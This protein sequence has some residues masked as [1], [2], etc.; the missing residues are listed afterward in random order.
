MKRGPIIILVV[1]ITISC[2]LLF[3][4]SR[5]I[6]TG[7]AYVPDSAV[8]ERLAAEKQRLEGGRTWLGAAWKERR[9][10][11][12]IISMTGGP[13]EMGYQHGTLLRDEIFSGV[14]PVFADPVTN[15]REHRAKPMFLRKLMLAYLD[16]A[17]FGPLERNTPSE[18][19]M[20]LKGIADGSG[21]G[22]RDLVR[23]TFKSELTMIM[24]P[25]VVKGK[26][27]SLGISAECSDFAAAGSATADGKLI[28]GRNT[29][30]AG[31]GR[32][33]DAQTVF[34]YRPLQGYAYVN[35]ST[36]GLIKCNSAV[37]E[38]GIVIGGH[39]MGFD[40]TGPRGMSF[41][42]LE[43]EIMRKA[44]T[45]DEAVDIVKRGPRAG[46]FGFMVADGAKRDAVA[47]EANGELVGVRRMENGV[48]VLTNFATTVELEKVDLMKRNNL[49]MRDM[50]GRY[51]R[52]GELIAASR[53]RITG[54]MAAS[55]M[56]DRLDMVTRT[57]RATGITV[58]AANNVTSAVFIPEDGIVWIASGVEPACDGRFHGLDVRAELTG[59]PPRRLPV[60]TGY[61]WKENSKQKGLRH[62]MKAYAAHEED[63]FDTTKIMTNLNAAIAL[64]PNESIYLRL[65][66]SL[67]L[68][69][70]TYKEAITLLERSLDMPQSNSERAHALLL[71]GQGLDLMGERDRAIA[72]YRMAEAI[73]AAHG[74]DILKGVN[75]MLAGFCKKYIEKPFT[76]KQIADIPVAFSSESGIE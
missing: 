35:I 51:L 73:H 60:L 28:M 3:I 26:A 30:Y 34:I 27:K 19:L 53:G 15:S 1:I 6:S 14:V 25:G 29:D 65:K 43:H 49:V 74:P 41:T 72:R 13:Y 17:V 55:F 39:F 5:L 36:A 33:M 57:E 63:P 10:E 22:Y 70:G 54:G 12:I 50:L 7:S 8:A 59:T 62:F 31:Q 52:V 18:Y 44:S 47:I 69:S 61:A 67:L 38:N 16:F 66:A 64:D 76:V 2:G 45:I 23:A 71:A 40:G 24:L 48:L 11:G 32:W 4:K 46:A 9:P 21:M 58:G 75:H 56:G 42:V 20:E 37:N 68:Y